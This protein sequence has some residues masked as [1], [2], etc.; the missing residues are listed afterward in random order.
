[1]NFENSLDRL[2]SK[3]V[4][5]K[6]LQSFTAF[7]RVLLGLSFIPPS[8]PKILHQP[9]TILPVSNPVGYY[10]DALY[11]TGYYY[12]F[13][14]WSQL[15]AVLLMLI[16][17]TSHIGALLFFPI[18]VN[19]AVLTNSVGFKGTWLITLLM[20]IAC[21]YLVCWDYPRWK[22]IIFSPSLSK[23]HFSRGVLASI[24]VI[25]PVG[26]VAFFGAA[27]LFVMGSGNLRPAFFLV[28]I[29]GGTLFG[30]L[31]SI[32]MRFMKYSDSNSG[33]ARF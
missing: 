14:G 4:N 6:L 16:P 13:I 26:G 1:M 10:F 5:S 27:Q 28:V 24:P 3:T 7:V 12:D 31:V 25:I 2:H 21:L 18:I 19:I 23:T 22:S 30:A 9:F 20:A 15:I 32:H 33:A 11:K 29:L 8:I 17:R